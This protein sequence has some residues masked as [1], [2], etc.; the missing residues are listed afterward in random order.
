V[1]RHCHNCQPNSNSPGEKLFGKV[2]GLT[3]N[4]FVTHLAP[5]TIKMPH[6]DP[7]DN[8][9]KFIS[10]KQKKPLATR[11]EE[12]AAIRVKFPTKVPVI[13]ERF[14]KEMS[15]PSLD[16]TKFLVPQEIT[17]SQFI[18]IIRN[19]LQLNSQQA[20]Y[21]LVSNRNLASLSRP[22][23]QIYRDYRDEDGFLYVTYASQEVFG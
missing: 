20:L 1:A 23:A 6:I 2:P 4:S 9:K 16:K 21:L 18:T 5:S 7:N 19:R 14:H 11:K 8:T 17:M 13:V 12:V 10:F 22:L 15:L 3:V